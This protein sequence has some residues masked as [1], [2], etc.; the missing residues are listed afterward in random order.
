LD[1]DAMPRPGSFGQFTSECSSHAKCFNGNV[2][3]TQGT[4]MSKCSEAAVRAMPPCDKRVCRRG[5]RRSAAH[6]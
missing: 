6:P 3:Y 2:H 4:N 1:V 5:I